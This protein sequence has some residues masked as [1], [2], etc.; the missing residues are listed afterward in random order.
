MCYEPGL[1]RTGAHDVLHGGGKLQALFLYTSARTVPFFRRPCMM[2][3]KIF[4]L[5]QVTFDIHVE[6]QVGIYYLHYKRTCVPEFNK[7]L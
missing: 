6:N 4:S 5:F 2:Q 3:I 1:G 7:K